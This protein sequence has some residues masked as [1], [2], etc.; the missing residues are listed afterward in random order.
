MPSQ[1]STA[2]SA[3]GAMR[4]GEPAASGPYAD[5]HRHQHQH[6]RDRS[7]AENV[8][9]QAENERLRLQLLALAEAYRDAGSGEMLNARYICN[10]MWTHMGGC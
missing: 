1:S 8:A 2:S 9:L 6:Q 4:S 5:A 7:A 3:M 10:N